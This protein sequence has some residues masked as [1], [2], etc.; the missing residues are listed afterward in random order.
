[1]EHIKK[2]IVTTIK[3]KQYWATFCSTFA[4]AMSAIFFLS[5]NPEVNAS[6]APVEDLEEF[7]AII[8]QENE[9]AAIDAADEEIEVAIAEEE[10]PSGEEARE[11]VVEL[12]SGDTFLNILTSQ[13]L[14]YNEANNIYLAV[15]KVYDPRNLR[16]G[17]K[18]RFNTTW[19]TAANKLVSV[20]Q[21]VSAVKVGEKFIVERNEDGGYVAQL[22]KDELIGEIN[23]ASGTIEGNLSVSMNSQKVPSRIVANFINIFSYSIDFR[24]D[25]KR[26]DKFE[27]IYENFITPDGQIVQNG[28]I[29]YASLTLGKNKIDLYRFKDASGNVD[30]YDANGLAMKKTLSRK[31]MS[32]QNARISSPFG[33][34][35]HPIYRDVRI[36]WGVD[37]AAPRNSLV[38]AAGDGVVLSAKYN[39]GYGNY[40]KIRHNSEFSTAYGHMQKFAKGIK[41]GVRVK[42]G[43]VIGYV[44]ST[45]RSTGPHLHYEVVKNG[46]RVNPLTIKASASENLRGRNLANFKQVV[47]KI[48]NTHQK[49]FAKKE[50]EKLAHNEAMPMPVQQN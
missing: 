2:Q 3:S 43:Q 19:D 35:R 9:Y 40:I 4:V 44:G 27:I 11:Q 25:V 5:H 39:G 18:I 14:D 15:K 23:S 48:R 7:A 1:M 41:P 10:A 49:M 13:G 33:K 28:D 12:K 31:P 29:L 37:Y 45:G 38:Y 30:Y 26:G 16:A 36:H 32:Y 6:V 21:I 50:A 24:R 20:N 47:A 42:Q 22:Q 46:K 17:Q 8:D 34:R